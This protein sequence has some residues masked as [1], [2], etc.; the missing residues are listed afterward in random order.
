MQDS[1]DRG[2]RL[3]DLKRLFLMTKVHGPTPEP[4]EFQTIALRLGRMESHALVQL[5]IEARR[6][7]VI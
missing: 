4:A 5:L 7:G 6:A 1:F 3:R 2:T